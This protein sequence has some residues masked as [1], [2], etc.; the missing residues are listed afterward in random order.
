MV[1]RGAE[2]DVDR[3]WLVP[4]HDDESGKILFMSWEKLGDEVRKRRKSLGL[5]QAEVT[6]RGGPSVETLRAV[7]NNQTGR[8]SRQS[9]RA[10]ERAIEW[11]P[12]S[13]DDVLAGATPRLADSAASNAEPSMTEFLAVISAEYFAVA[14]Q[15]V[16]MKQAFVRHRDS[17]A[18]PERGALE[19]EITLSARETEKS[20]I[21]ILSQL[22][23]DD[24]RGMAIHLLSE[25]R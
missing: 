7:E 5:T 25:L 2:R 9:R 10:L 19:E 3:A 1:E 23:D 13:I 21:K 14:E 20:V 16:K 12:G 24:D 11:E 18:E 6:T 8:L 15:V 17:I 22:D 4:A